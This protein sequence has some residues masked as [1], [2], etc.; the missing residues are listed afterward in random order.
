VPSC[1]L[2]YSLSEPPSPVLSGMGVV[3]DYEISVVIY[4]RTYCLLLSG[5]GMCRQGFP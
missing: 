2:V 1:G 3:L 5:I 4:D